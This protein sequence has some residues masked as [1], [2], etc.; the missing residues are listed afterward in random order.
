MGDPASS[1]A[2]WSTRISPVAGVKDGVVRV[3]PLVTEATGYVAVGVSV[4]GR[5]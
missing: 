5:P 3:A 4:T 2:V 1:V